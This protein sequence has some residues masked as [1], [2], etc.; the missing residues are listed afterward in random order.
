MVP[1]A[2]IVPALYAGAYIYS[3]TAV[4][5]EGPLLYGDRLVGVAAISAG[6][7]IGCVVMQ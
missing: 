2:A 1:V 5:T 4:Q 3:G 6:R 7:W